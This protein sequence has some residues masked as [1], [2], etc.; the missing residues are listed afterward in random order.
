MK[1]IFFWPKTIAGRESQGICHQDE[2]INGK[3]P[4]VK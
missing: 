4:I 3:P 2:L 1:A